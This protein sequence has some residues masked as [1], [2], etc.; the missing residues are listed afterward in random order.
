ME[1]KRLLVGFN[2]DILDMKFIPRLADN[3]PLFD[4]FNTQ[5]S[6]PLSLPLDDNNSVT[7]NSITT[8]TATTNT[9]TTNTNTTNTATTN[10][11]TNTATTNTATTNTN[12]NTAT[13]NAMTGME[14]FYSNYALG[15]ITNSN[16]V[17]IM[18]SNFNFLSLNGHTDIVLAIDITP[19]G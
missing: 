10:T 16:Q 14:P 18:D 15:L 11:N 3:Q 6:L 7:T 8:N 1:E 19:D 12:T 2:D 17:R 13:T 9:A 4:Y 5:L